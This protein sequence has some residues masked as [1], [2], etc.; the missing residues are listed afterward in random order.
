[1]RT[2]DNPNSI[3][4]LTEDGGPPQ[5]INSLIEEQAVQPFGSA[6]D[7]VD[8]ALWDDGDAVDVF[9]EWVDRHRDQAL[10]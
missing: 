7:L 6:Q 1:M 3:A 8:P 4:R 5:S 10:L 2:T 9:L